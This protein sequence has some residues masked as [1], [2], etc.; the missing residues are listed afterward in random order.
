[1]VPLKRFLGFRIRV[2]FQSKKH[3][4][5][6]KEKEKEKKSRER[7]L[8]RRLVVKIESRF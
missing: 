3:A 7:L 8:T 1:V 2:K 4:K 6:R 5:K